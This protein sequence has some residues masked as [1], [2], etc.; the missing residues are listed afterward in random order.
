MKT[1][2]SL[3]TMLG[4]A[5]CN[6]GSHAALTDSISVEAGISYNNVSTSG[7]LA[8][9][10]DSTSASILLGSPLS[11]GVASVGV[12]L[13]R[14]GGETEADVNIA[15]GVPLTLFNVTLDTEVYFQKI[16][17]SYG[18]WEEVGIGA[19]YGFDWVEVGATLWHELGSNAGYGIELTA[20][21]EFATPVDGLTVSP[22]IAVN[23]ADSYDAIE[24]GVSADYQLTEDV[25]VSA[26]ASFNDND[27]DGTDYSLSKD[28][29]VGAS[30][31]YS[32]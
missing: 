2:I 22:F 28:W 29:V 30:L 26:K 24:V 16:D 23:F 6:A 20:S 8:T 19:A 31:T 4:V 27:A 7:G 21:R 25:V 15:W 3:I 32:F 10:G 12:D 5:I 1:L 18:G 13:H 11:G 9:R 17:S 14:A